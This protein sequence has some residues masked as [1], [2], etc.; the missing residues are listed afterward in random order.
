[1]GSAGRYGA[2]PGQSGVSTTVERALAT[3]QDAL[4]RLPTPNL[5]LAELARASHVSEQHLCRLFADELELSPMETF[6]QLRLERALLLLT[7]SSLS[8]QEIGH[9]TGFASGFH[10]SRAFRTLYGEP[11]TVVRRRVL[12]GGTLPPSRL[13]AK[14]LASANSSR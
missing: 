4:G 5:T 9:R 8:M 11:P 14:V 10:F 2:S 12:A 3:I 7:H 6:R 1:M 13:P